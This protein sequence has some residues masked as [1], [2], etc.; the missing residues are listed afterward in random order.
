[1]KK[2]KGSDIYFVD[3]YGNVYSLYKKGARKKL[4]DTPLRIKQSVCGSGY[5]IFHKYEDGKRKTIMIHRVVAEAFIENPLSLPVVNH[6]DGNKYNNSVENLEWCSYK[7]N[8]GHAREMGLWVPPP[9]RALFTD[10][11]VRH[12]RLV[13]D[14]KL[15]KVFAEAHNVDKSSICRIRLRLSY[16]DVA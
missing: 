10:D 3:E 1:M 9:R 7:E 6:K 13:N 8:S 11:Q 4:N 5:P 14:M 15:D 16:K 12:I 2:I